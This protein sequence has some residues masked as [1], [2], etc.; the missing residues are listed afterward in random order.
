[1]PRVNKGLSLFEVPAKIPDGFIYHQ[2]F[3]SEVEERELIREIRKLNLTPFK[4][5]QF[6]GKRRTVS[7]GWNY[8]FGTSSPF[9][10]VYVAITSM[11]AGLPLRLA[12]RPRFS[13]SWSF[14]GSVTCSP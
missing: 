13:A 6:T 4:Y 7:F 8:E 3:I 10:V 11:I 14:S 5:Y 2:N 9:R 12:S 1:M